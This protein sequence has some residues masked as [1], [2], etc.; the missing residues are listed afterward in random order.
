MERM[1]TCM[2]SLLDHQQ[3]LHKIYGEFQEAANLAYQVLDRKV[4]EFEQFHS[5]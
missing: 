5:C 4:I 2:Q 1:S 3:A